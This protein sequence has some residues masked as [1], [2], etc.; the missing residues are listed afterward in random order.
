MLA[1]CLFLAIAGAAV[2]TTIHPPAGVVLVA[3]FTAMGLVLRG[4]LD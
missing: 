3:V 4:L 2:V 1:L